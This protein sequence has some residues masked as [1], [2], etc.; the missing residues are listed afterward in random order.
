MSA[1]IYSSPLEL[2]RLLSL[3]VLCIPAQVWAAD[4]TEVY[5]K[6]CK[7]CHRSGV[8]EA[9]MLSNKEEWAKRLALGKPA[10]Q[11]SVIEGK[12]NM[13]PRAGKESLTD[14]EISAAID[15]IEAQVK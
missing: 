5:E 1:N 4:G 14:E 9:P 10:L 11:K 12:G 7:K 13:N 15:Y 3:T 8:D 6:V 2:V